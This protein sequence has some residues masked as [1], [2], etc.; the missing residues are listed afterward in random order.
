MDFKISEVS[1]KILSAHYHLQME[2]GLSSWLLLE[3]IPVD[4][5]TCRYELLCLGYSIF[6][7]CILRTSDSR[8]LIAQVAAWL[9]CEWNWDSSD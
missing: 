4:E 7:L 8:A 2:P 5:P 6:P 3:T 9:T 1:S